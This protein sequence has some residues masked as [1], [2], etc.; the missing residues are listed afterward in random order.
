[1]NEIEMK[2]FNM[3][4]IEDSELQDYRSQI[5]HSNIPF[6]GKIFSRRRFMQIFW[7][8]PLETIPTGNKGRITR[9]RKVNNFLIYIESKCRQ[10]FVPDKYLSIGESTVGF[11][12][13]ISFLAYN[14]KKPTKWGLHIY[15]VS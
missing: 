3:G 14:P 9:T 5:F 2:A 4:L 7:T 15:I 12:G 11:K 8:L 1:M 13:R 10:H 6:F